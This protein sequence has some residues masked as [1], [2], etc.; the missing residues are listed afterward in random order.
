MSL[1]VRKLLKERLEEEKLLGITSDDSSTKFITSAYKQKLQEEKK[2]DYEDKIEEEIERRNEV[3]KQ[4]DGLVGFYTNLLTNNIAY[5]GDVAVSAVSAYTAG[6]SRQAH[7]NS[8]PAVPSHINSTST[9][10]TADDR[11]RSLGDNSRNSSDKHIETCELHH[12]ADHEDISVVLK[13]DT[14]I[15]VSGT[16]RSNNDS[17]NDINEMKS[18]SDNNSSSNTLTE[19][20]AIVE[21]EDNK[22]AALSAARLRFLQRKK[23]KD[24][25]P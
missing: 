12:N 17:L 8:T 13:K 20:R 1:D 2:W 9:V 22:E 23:Q 6:S 25:H 5:G 19:K 18:S 15:T 10:P 4:K 7:V 24:L 14:A 16:K 11:V 21:A 3:T